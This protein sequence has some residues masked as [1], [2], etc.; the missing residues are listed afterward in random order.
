MGVD[1]QKLMVWGVAAL[2][3][4][5]FVDRFYFTPWYDEMKKLRTDLEGVGR[6]LAVARATVATAPA[7]KAE[8]KV[9]NDRLA[10]AK[11]SDTLNEFVIG[12]GKLCADAGVSNLSTK[13]GREQ[14]VGER[15]E[16]IEYAVET[17]FQATWEPFVRLLYKIACEKEFLKV[18][19]LV[20][21]S[22]YEKEDRLD[23]ELR[24][25]TIELAQ[26]GGRP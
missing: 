15:G 10:R 16:F 17:N 20:I 14:K 5:F 2:A 21:T 26:A 9:L 12:L 7:V 8:W 24:A 25:S 18:Q 1:R 6:Q 23:V 3:A 19:R 4:A 11:E 22:K 13:P